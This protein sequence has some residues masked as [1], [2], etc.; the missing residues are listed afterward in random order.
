MAFLALV[1]IP[2]AL[3]S[4][5]EPAH[6]A[7]VVN[8]SANTQ[9]RQVHVVCQAAGVVVLDVHL[10]IKVPPVTLPSVTLPPL[11]R[12]TRT[13]RVHVPGPPGPTKTV[14]VQQPHAT[15]TVT[16]NVPGSG[17]KTITVRPEAPQNPSQPRVTATTTRTVTAS[18]SSETGQVKRPSDTIAPDDDDTVLSF[19]KIDL[20]TPEAVGFGTLALVII[21]G[22]ILLGMYGGYYLGFKDS[23]NKEMKFLRSLLRK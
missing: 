21:A 18:P 5:N 2:F 20:S 12:A 16:V 7:P 9:G 17:T 19:P 3:A 4:N 23:D 1:M 6:A 10:P 11:P 8:C 15:Q 22:L 14:H 13:I